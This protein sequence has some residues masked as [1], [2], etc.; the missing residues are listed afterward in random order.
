MRKGVELKTNKME[1]IVS[2]ID[3]QKVGQTAAEIRDTDL[4]F[5]QAIGLS[6]H[7]SPTRANGLLAMIKRIKTYAAVLA[8]RA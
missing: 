3:K 5:V 4:Y 2:G 7:L 6:E 1:I 8:A